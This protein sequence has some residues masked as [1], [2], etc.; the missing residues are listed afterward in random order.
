MNLELRVQDPEWAKSAIATVRELAGT[1]EA[2]M[3]KANKEGSFPRAP[4]FECGKRGLFA[5][6]TPKDFGGL[7]FGVP[8]YCLVEEEIARYGLVS[9]QTQVQG[10]CW[11]NDWGTPAQKR[12]YL[13]G[14]ANGSLIFSE[15]ISEPSAASS[16]KNLKS[17]AKRDGNGWVIRGE[18]CHI[19]MGAECDVTLV[20]AMA[21]E[22]LTA[23]LVD[24]D[25]PGLR[26]E[27]TH[28]IGIRFSPTANMY[29]DEV[30]VADDAI[31]GKVGDGLAT[32]VSTFN[33]SRL[34]NASAL[35]GY[36]RRALAE[37][38]QYARTRQVGTNVVTDFQGNQW[39]IAECYAAIHAAS[40]ARDHAANLAA[41]GAE[42]AMQTSIAKQLA[43]AA[44]EKTVNEVYALIGGHG[45]YEEQNF[46]QYI[47][48]VKL[49][50]V[51]G[52]STEVLKNH[53][54]RSILKDAN[55]AGLT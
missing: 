35:V 1:F 33:V 55:L 25:K 24:T 16:L 5:A 15:S 54:A 8:E 30:R 14:L 26:R 34:G 29:F 44:A 32:F 39:T 47:F 17:T 7:G 3:M 12:K 28:P 4:F 50:R 19:N 42:H 23:F 53:I 21:P 37:A 38:V 27:H 2:Q 49:L 43:I 31:L 40:L 51:A 41:R 22:G 52:G 20:Y 18:K 13:P 46:G 11:L 48:D 36:A 10:Q 9:G 45:L 6:I